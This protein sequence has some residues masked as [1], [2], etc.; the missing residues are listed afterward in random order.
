M[1]LPSLKI[2]YILIDYVRKVYEVMK[3]YQ[4]D[5]IVI[6]SKTIMV[7]FVITNT[8]YRVDKKIIIRYTYSNYR[9]FM[10]ALK[11]PHLRLELVDFNA[12]YY[13]F[14]TYIRIIS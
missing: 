7:C 1:W 6:C 5:C 11:L 10:I 9:V 4:V 12:C 14:G 8:I 3:N 2:K 13:S